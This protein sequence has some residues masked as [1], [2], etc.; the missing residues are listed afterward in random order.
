MAGGRLL[1]GMIVV[2]PGFVGT[3][4]RIDGVKIAVQ[5]GVAPRHWYIDTGH[6]ITI[7]AA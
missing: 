6:W 3:Q 4:A 5:G 2:T 7:C 1:I